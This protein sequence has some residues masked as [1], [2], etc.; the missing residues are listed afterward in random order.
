M[1]SFI[2][3]PGH[4]KIIFKISDE[5]KNKFEID[6]VA[7]AMNRTVCIDNNEE[8]LVQT[9]PLEENCPVCSILFE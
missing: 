8:P 6:R 4:R 5:L 7:E 3:L 2:F 9:R 1:K